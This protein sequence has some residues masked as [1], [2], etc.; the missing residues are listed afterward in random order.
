[1]SE[2]KNI[3]IKLMKQY[4]WGSTSRITYWRMKFFHSESYYTY[5]F[6]LHLRRYEYLIK[7]KTTPLMK[8]RRIW[9]L[10]RYS[11]FAKDCGFV[12]GDGILGEGVTFYHRGNIVI[13][14]NARV[15]EGCIFHGS[16]CIGA[17]HLG[18]DKC[19]VLGKNVEIG[20]G[21]V[22]LGDITIADDIII[23]A[24]SVV[25][26]SFTEPGIIIAGAPARKIRNKTEVLS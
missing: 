4:L 7:Q 15:G 14:P 23:G 26:K 5:R 19:P 17:S 6:L 2:W 16:C 13:N 3:R 9:N 12:I 1:M 10:K 25:T 24:N 11:K 18:S 20:Y 21:A 22:I 8:L